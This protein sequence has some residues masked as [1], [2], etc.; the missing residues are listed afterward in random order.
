MGGGGGME[1]KVPKR[2]MTTPERWEMNQLRG[3]GAV[4]GSA[5]ADPDEDF[6]QRESR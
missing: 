5:I 1:V 6:Q 4:A 2:R 3:S